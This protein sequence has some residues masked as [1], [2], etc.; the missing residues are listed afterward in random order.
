M[1]RCNAGSS[2]LRVLRHIRPA[3]ILGRNPAFERVGS[4]AKEPVAIAPKITLEIRFADRSPITRTF[5]PGRMAIGRESGDVVLGDPE[6]SALHAELEFT[7]GRVIVRDLGS[8]NGTL[9][10]GKAMPQFALFAG[11]AFRCGTTDIVLLKI[12][13]VGATPTPGGTAAGGERVDDVIGQSSAT[14]EGLGIHESSTTLPESASPTLPGATTA[15]SPS[16]VLAPGGTPP[17]GLAPPRLN[18]STHVETDDAPVVNAATINPGELAA[19]GSGGVHVPSLT[20]PKGIDAPAVAPPAAVVSADAS[21]KT[22]IPTTPSVQPGSTQTAAPMPV[23]TPAPFAAAPPVAPPPSAA[24]PVAAPPVAAPVAAPPVAAPPVV[25]AAAPPVVSAA[26]PLAAPTAPRGPVA[27]AVIKPGEI[28]LGP[29]RHK[30]KR[31]GLDVKRALKWVAAGTLGAAA[32]A[33]IA[34]AIYTLVLGRGQAFFGKMAAELP[35]DSIGVLAFKSPKAVLGLAETEIPEALT[36]LA[37]KDLGFDPLDLSAYEALGVDVDAPVGIGLLSDEGHVSLSVGV[38]DRETFKEGLNKTLKQALRLDDDLR[39]IERSYEDV[40]G[41]WLDEPVSMAV[42]WPDKRAIFVLGPESGETARL[43]KE[44]AKAQSGDNLSTRPGFEGIE[45]QRG[46]LLAGAYVDVASARAALQ[47][48]GRD[49]AAMLLALADIEGLAFALIDDGPRLALVWQTVVR[50]GAEM[51][52][53]VEGKARE[54]KALAN[55]PATALASGDVRINGEAIYRTL[56]STALGL[57]LKSFED[58]LKERTSL[59]LRSDILD[60]ITGEYGGAL[61][62]MPSGDS[63]EPLD[64][65]EPSE[66]DT[67]KSWAAVSWIALKDEEQAKKSAERFFAANQSRLKLEQV[68]G[69]TVYVDD[70]FMP[71]SYFIHGGHLWIAVGGPDD[72][73]AIIEGPNKALATDPRV[74]EIGKAVEKGGVMAGYFDVRQFLFAARPLMSEREREEEKKLAPLLSPIEVLTMR[75]E[76]RKRAIVTR[77]TLHTTWDRAASGIVKAAIE[78][79]GAELAESIEQSRRLDKCSTLIDHLMDLM[80]KELGEE[81]VSGIEYETRS[82]MLEE[83][84]SDQTTAAE[85]KCMGNAESLEA[86]TA[87]EGAGAEAGG[88]DGTTPA[89]IEQGEPTPVP[90]IDDIWP[91]TKP[92]GSGNGRPDATVNYGVSLGDEPQ[93]RGPDNALVTIVMFGDFQC[94]YCKR[95]LGTLDEI[96]AKHGK[97]VRIVFRHNPLAMHGE[98]RPAARAAMA[99]GKQGKFWPMHD[100]L[101]DNQHALTEAN[102]VS[103]ASGMGLDVAKFER[104]FADRFTETQIDSDVA[105]AQT[106]GAKL[107]PSFFVNGR[108]LSGAQPLHVFEAV[109]TEELARAKTF[110]ER[111]GNTRKG[112]YDDMRSHFATEVTKPPPAPVATPKSGSRYTIETANLPRRGSSAIARV[113][114]VQC[115]DFDCPF[116]KRST[117]TIDEIATAYPTQVAIYWLHN[118]LSFHATAEPAA[119][120]AVAAA[121]QDKFWEMHDKLY[122][123]TSLRSD[124]DFE[125]IA[126]DLGLDV[127]KFKTDFAAP[128]TKDLVAEQQ[129]TCVDNDAR[130]TP[131]F[132]VNGR[133][134]TGA[135][136]FDRFKE[137]IDEEL[138]GGI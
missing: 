35:Q 92:T 95:S 55:V 112:L 71:V 9:K 21:P 66:P 136:P 3:G 51:L 78:V 85:I 59:D 134:V 101:F 64:G 90:F 43:A 17:P 72:I 111:R 48:P 131:S 27:N 83:C 74:P 34:F 98:A 23:A 47:R 91:N 118:P 75:S 132:F 7:Q 44:V 40:P 87:C 54:P 109:I 26:A 58:E 50:D 28:D 126:K 94:P 60:N 114:L 41:M 19:D 77:L 8:R 56:S 122:A 93:S 135:Q 1:A 121:N 53:L 24:P 31:K 80:R 32:V 116:C 15:T 42:L 79:A 10:D 96:M 70:G 113:E 76:T 127:A 102:F 6:T 128:E 67:A 82:Q 84:L 63:D 107:T 12:D 125:T 57:G 88:D 104:D 61:L 11:Q 45:R 123:E 52:A 20:I 30:A 39:F 81:A 62:R 129:K 29:Q 138:A 46:K 37:T 117:K 103:W 22:V 97:D 99:A 69:T 16:T 18:L 38:T 124:A 86:L 120:A 133:L 100:K 36:E 49:E 25:A 119:R 13:G 130:G 105:E 68:A 108:H 137:V 106:F 14:L 33:G 65:G 89:V 73:A 5:G 2:S 4:R 110:V 115:G